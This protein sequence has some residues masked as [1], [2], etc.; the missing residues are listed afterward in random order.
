MRMNLPPPPPGAHLTPLLLFYAINLGIV[1]LAVLVGGRYLVWLWE[2]HRFPGP[3]SPP[4]PGRRLLT[5]G[6]GALWV[7]DA[8]LQFQPLMVTQFLSGMLTPLLAHEPAVV[9]RSLSIGMHLWGLNPVMANLL[10]AW[11]QLAIGLLILL[12]GESRWRRAGLL[13][14]LGWGLVVFVVGEGMGSLFVHGSWLVG[15]PGSGLLYAVA[16]AMLLAPLAWWTGP[17]IRA[18]FW[19]VVGGTFLLAALLQAWPPSGWWAGQLGRYLAATAATPQ[20]AWISAPIRAWSMSAR[21]HPFDWNAI[22]VGVF[23]ALGLG[24]VAT[25]GRWSGPLWWASTAVV[26]AT[27]WLGQDFGILGGMGTD[28]NSG[29]VVLVILL[30]SAVHLGHFRRR[31]A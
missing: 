15:S 18:V 2:H 1:T 19:R 11:L 14:S 20:P 22:L 12:G 26:F 4:L 30:A 27:W 5:A 8:V 6:L 21:L 13:L 3:P 29:A 23:L 24:W 16:S 17:A 31:P 7:L 25:R 9:A 10:A 28:P